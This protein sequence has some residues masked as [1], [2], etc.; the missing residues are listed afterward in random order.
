METNAKPYF[1]TET[2]SMVKKSKSLNLNTATS[3]STPSGAGV[4]EQWASQ[5]AVSAPV[6]IPTDL[7]D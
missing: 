7:K 5:T 4:I 2:M 3:S 1:N 6:T